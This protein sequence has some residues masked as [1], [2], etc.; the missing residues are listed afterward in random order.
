MADVVLKRRCKLLS[1]F[2]N[3]YVQTRSESHWTESGQSRYVVDATVYVNSGKALDL[4][5]SWIADTAPNL[6]LPP[7]D[8]ATLFTGSVTFSE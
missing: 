3:N 7:F 5:Q 4:F 1:F 8:Q 2:Y 6:D